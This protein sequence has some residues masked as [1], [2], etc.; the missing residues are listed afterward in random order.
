MIPMLANV[1]MLCPAQ[2]PVISVKVGTGLGI[3]IGGKGG[4]GVGATGSGVPP[5]PDGG[6]VTFFT[7]TVAVKI[8]EILSPGPFNSVPY[9]WLF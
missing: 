7:V 3:M 8:F 2:C 1:L 4:S 5:P 6:G 9:T